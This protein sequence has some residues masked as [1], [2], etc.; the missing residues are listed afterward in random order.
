SRWVVRLN[1]ALREDRFL[2]AFQPVVRLA[3]GEV[4]HYEVL[5]RLR[6]ASGEVIPPGAF[7]PAAER[8]GLMPQIDRW[9]VDHALPLLARQPSLHLF[10]TLSGASLGHEELLGHVEQ[11][12]RGVAGLDA[13]LTLE[14]TETAAVTDLLQA[15]HWM[16][17]LLEAGCR[18]A[19]DDFGIGFSS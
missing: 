18:F 3:T 4:E 9:V 10:V 11:R 17:K 5:L 7:L 19:L 13:R 15:Q 6:G 2:L 1:D 12:T 8:F 16:K 14:I